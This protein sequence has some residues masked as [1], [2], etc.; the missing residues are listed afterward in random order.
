MRYDGH[1]V[2]VAYEC[3]NSSNLKRDSDTYDCWFESNHAHPHDYMVQ[4]RGWYIG[5]LEDK[6]SSSLGQNVFERLCMHAVHSLT[7]G[8]HEGGSPHSHEEPNW[9]HY[10][11]CLCVGDK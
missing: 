6:V 5:T 11:A 4:G 8:R 2:C 1:T 10:P 3:L 7:L 9:V